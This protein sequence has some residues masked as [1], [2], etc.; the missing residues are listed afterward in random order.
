MAALLSLGAGFQRWLQRRKPVDLRLGEYVSGRHLVDAVTA[1]RN[2]MAMQ[3]PLV[4]AA[5][6]FTSR[7]AEA[8]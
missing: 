6:S 1:P 4:A 8:I 7:S 2:W 3:T 5:A